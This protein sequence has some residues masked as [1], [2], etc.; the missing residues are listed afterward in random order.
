MALA[1]GDIGTGSRSCCTK[2]ICLMT[3][4]ITNNNAPTL[5]TDGVPNFPDG[6]NQVKDTGAGYSGR[7]HKKSTILIRSTAGSGTMVGTFVLWGYL[8]AAAAWYP[9]NLNGG[10]ALAEN[11]ADQLYL[12]EVVD[13]LG[14]FDR[15]YLEVKAIGGTATAFEAW[16]VTGLPVP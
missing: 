6:T 10:T 11:S 12:R 9:I 3:A 8:T 7:A 16:H 13:E 15:L 14:M 1:V 4:Q 2:S 5:A